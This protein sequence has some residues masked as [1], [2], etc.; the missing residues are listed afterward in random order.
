MLRR[1]GAGLLAVA[2]IVVDCLLV[3]GVLVVPRSAAGPW[4]TP[5]ARATFGRRLAPAEIEQL[6]RHPDRVKVSE[7]VFVLSV[8]EAASVRLPTGRV[9]ASDGTGPQN[10]AAFTTTVPPGTYPVLLLQAA[11]A[12]V[13]PTNAAALIRVSDAVPASWRIATVPG[14]DASQLRPGEVFMY[15]VDSGLGCF[16][17]PEAVQYMNADSTWTSRVIDQLAASRALS[18]TLTF[19]GADG[20]NVVEFVSGYGDG[21]YPTFFGFDAA[22]KPVAVLTDFG[23]IDVVG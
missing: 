8:H 13:G 14:Q 18:T 9:V 12:G 19:G 17:S 23:I 20:P 16:T 2:V 11:P 3:A 7:G 15:P 5:A 1:Y 10:A 6:F 4:A 21:G 22:G